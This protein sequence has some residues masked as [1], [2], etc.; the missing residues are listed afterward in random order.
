M[1][2][3][4]QHLE[5]VEG[6]EI[7]FCHRCRNEW[8]QDEHPNSLTCPSCHGEFTEII[9]AE[10]DPRV[11]DEGSQES[12]ADH[13]FLSFAQ[14]RRRFRDPDSD[15][16][17]ED[18]DQHN[19]HGPGRFFGQQNLHR[20]PGTS[21]FGRA[22]RIRP[23]N[24]DDIIR[25]FTEMISD[26]SPPGMVGRS[27]PDTLFREDQAAPRVVYRT[28]QGPGF[29]G[30][31]SS[32]TVTTGSSA[33]RPRGPGSP[34]G[35]A[36]GRGS[37]PGSGPAE[38]GFPR[39]FSELMGNLGGPPMRQGD[40]EGQDANRGAGAGGGPPDLA[41]IVQ[42]LATL[43]H[44]AAFQGD[45]AYSQEELDR[46][47]SNLMEANPQS[48]APPP[49]TENAIAALP[50]K[51]L[52]EGMLGPELKG[53][54]TICID[55]VTVGVE[56]MVLP[57]RHWFHE[58]CAKLWLE[59]HN[60]CPICRAA[61]DGSSAGKPP[62]EGNASQ[63][64]PQSSGPSTQSGAP[65]EAGPSGEERY[66]FRRASRRQNRGQSRSPPNESPAQRHSRARSPS[67]APCDQRSGDGDRSQ[68][69]R[70]SSGPLNWLRRLGR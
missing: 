12:D 59:Q 13:P 38:D 64:V 10:N 35:A 58:D 14:Q 44:P 37:S 41:H 4:G 54:C 25:R 32:F 28:F 57:C 60:S 24:S 46:I 21:E 7:V 55:E 9:S 67:D 15:P 51:K 53:E 6:R 49:A 8:Y 27:G 69:S 22:S 63:G 39:F 56:V 2:S 65:G 66:H 17:E 5:A 52:D 36:S 33:A 70:G 30:G 11:L 31:V 19:F 1:T 42:L 34:F 23:G 29:S 45:V 18:I 61:I 43:V 68:D 3:R 16:E 26:M 48:N 47:I 40:N 20:S 62:T 50:R